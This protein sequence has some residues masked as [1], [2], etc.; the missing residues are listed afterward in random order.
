MFKVLENSSPTL[1]ARVFAIT[2]SLALVFSF[3]SLS[4]GLSVAA[5][6]SSEKAFSPIKAYEA[7]YKLKS[8][9]YKLSAK[10]KR[11]L[12]INDQGLATLNQN[13]SLLMANISQTSEFLTKLD[14][15]EVDSKHY[16]YKR[17]VFGKKK[18]YRV[19]FDQQNKQFLENNNGD[20]KTLP[21]NVDMYDELSYQESLRCAL[22][23]SSEIK[24]DDAFEYVVRTKGKN[25]NYQFIISGEEKIDTKL[26]TV[27]AVKVSR[28]R[29]SKNEDEKSHIWF[30]KDH[31][32][33]LVKFFQQDK[34]DTFNLEIQKLEIK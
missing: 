31:D 24:E 14:S 30:S 7:T 2:C 8:K 28:V 20:K 22:K 33:L 12:S 27:N 21:I 15:C 10:A 29:S 3:I 19:E 13:A 1:T 18:N 34:D 32:F 11:S 17:K 5:E 23:N 6:V 16:A 26:G 9:K 25:K 4:S